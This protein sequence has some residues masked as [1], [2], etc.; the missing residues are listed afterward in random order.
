[1]IHATRQ[2]PTEKTMESNLP[3]TN[4]TEQAKEMLETLTKLSKPSSPETDNHETGYWKGS[5][6]IG[7]IAAFGFAVIAYAL[8]NKK[9]Q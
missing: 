8:A 9:E 1:M 5:A 6:V 7:V 2:Q 3:L 4:V